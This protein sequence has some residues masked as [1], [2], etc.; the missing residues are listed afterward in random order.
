MKASQK[1]DWFLH[2]SLF[3]LAIAS[4]MGLMSGAPNLVLEQA[5]WFI[6][7]FLIVFFLS[8]VD[9][10]PVINYRSYLFGGYFITLL[11]VIS[12]LFFA[13]VIRQAQSW[14]V[15]GS[16]QFQPS[17]LIK[18]ALVIFLAYF[19]A[20]RHIGIAHVRNLVISFIYVAIPMIVLFLQPDWG[21][22]LVLFS[23]WLGFLLVSGIRWRHLIIGTILLAIMGV[24]AWNF[25]LAPYHKERI[26]G[27]LEPTY[28]PLGINYSAI[29]SK[30]AIGSAGFLGKG[31]KHGTQT[32]LGFLTDPGTDFIFAALIEEW[33]FIG[34][35]LILIAFFSL[36][37]RIIMIGLRSEDTFSQFVCL[38]AVILFL[39][40]FMLNVGS[41]LGLLPVIGVT[42]PF[43]SYGGSSLLT[44]AILLGI[45][46]NISSRTTF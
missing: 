33:G 9:M 29:Q 26:I 15:I 5:I 35:L 17:E 4:L 45:I 2:G 6:L 38:G 20:R 41:A 39:T 7:G 24:I 10:R 23:L 36:I 37:L 42:F 13:P 11:I 3:F 14:L 16:F 30:I 40:E 43:L 18:I 28:D 27:F 1:Q 12:T 34:G 25:L 32:Q 46:H 19:F 44:K 8:N 21:S 31:F 22:A